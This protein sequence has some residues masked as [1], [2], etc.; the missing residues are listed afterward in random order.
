VAVILNCDELSVSINKWEIIA[1]LT[2]NQIFKQY[3]APWSKYK[4]H[5]YVFFINFKVKV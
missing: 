3:S 5:Y 4:V 2:N 1:Q